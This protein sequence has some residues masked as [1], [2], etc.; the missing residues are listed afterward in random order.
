MIA[1]L[2]R[3]PSRRL[4]SGPDDVEEI[5]AHPFFTKANI[6]WQQ[7]RDRKLPVPPV[8]IK[9]VVNQEIPTEKVYGT[10]AFDDAQKNKNR[11]NEWS[12]IRK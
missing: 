3:N 6:D 2:H 7:V 8:Q 11:I 9:R 10:S 5:K 12:Y 1:L 4:G